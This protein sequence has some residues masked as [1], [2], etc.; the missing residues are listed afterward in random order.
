MSFFGSLDTSASGLTAQRLRLDVISQNMANA[1]TTRTEEGGPYKRKSVVFE[2]V[3]N[4]PSSSFSS[5]LN[6][7]IQSGNN[8]VR[9]AQ[10]VE[11]ESEGS[12]VYDPTH[13]DANEEGYVEMP[14]VNTIDEMVNMISASRSY[15]A[16]VNSFNSMKAMFTK[17]LEIGK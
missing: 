13:P 8:G 1:S 17:A 14:N 2:Q 16:N 9:V 11:D 3:Q 12:L 7:K 10:I 5:I 15:E 6:K 4:E